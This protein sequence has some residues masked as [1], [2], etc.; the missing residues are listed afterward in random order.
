[1]VKVSREQAEQNAASI[2]RA[3]G[4]VL[5]EHGLETASVARIAAQADLTHGAVYRHYRDKDD[6]AAEAIRADF[7]TIVAMLEELADDGADLA[8]YVSAYLAPDHRDHFPWGCPA[9]PLA[10][11]VARARTGVKAAFT[12]GVRAN[13]AALA[14]LCGGDAEVA[15]GVLATL[16]GAMA[17]AR[18]VRTEDPEL[19]DGFLS[20]GRAM[21][22]RAE[23]D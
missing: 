15:R 22:L 13:L 12:E 16:V 7:R 9:A 8:A 6:L 18:A 1:M 5:R 19:S 20:A 2:L 21:A 4:Q 14:P 11:E 3:A 10:A 23:G 17:L